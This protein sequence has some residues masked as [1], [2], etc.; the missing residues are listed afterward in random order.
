MTTNEHE[1]GSIE[2]E[3][4][5]TTTNPHLSHSLRHPDFENFDKENFLEEILKSRRELHIAR[6][7]FNQVADPLLIDHV[8]F[9]IGAAERHLNYLFRLAREQNISFD[10]AQWE[11]TSDAWRLD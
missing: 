4:T 2:A 9:R 8:V 1:A 6:Q 11:W 3:V 10:G 7:Q 5:E